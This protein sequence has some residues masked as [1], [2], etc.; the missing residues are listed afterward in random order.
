MNE[1]KHLSLK[2]AFAK[3]KNS[4][5][6]QIPEIFKSQQLSLKDLEELEDILISSDI[7]MDSTNK[8]IESIKESFRLHKSSSSN[9]SDLIKNEIQNI[10]E[11]AKND[12]ISKDEN[13]PQILIMAGVN[14]V[15]KTTAIAKISHYF[16][17]R[18][19]SVLCGAA[20][21]YRAAA[22]DQIK[23]WG[24]K[25]N[26]EVISHQSG[27]DPSA[28]AFDTISAAKK[29][30]IDLV[31]IDT[32]GRL[33][34][35]SNLMDELKKIYKVLN[36]SKSHYKLHT[37]LTL[38]A[39]TGQN[40]L[41]QAK[42]FNESIKCDGIF[43]TKLDGTSKGG[44]IIPIIEETNIPISFIGTGEQP[45]DIALFDPNLFTEYVFN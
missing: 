36:Q 1:K 44:I 5:L 3:T 19:K 33:H 34:E 7:G 30:N 25:E 12:E 27:S 11:S 24:Q 2:N 14:G 15:G 26:F 39:T 10:L 4:F 40:G 22:I 29:R 20:D 32:A 37:L 28:V 6:G 35:N 21:T 8:I 23:L 13:F 31:I 43:L 18:G 41:L 45:T 9:L 38:D 16:Q 42:S 17:Q